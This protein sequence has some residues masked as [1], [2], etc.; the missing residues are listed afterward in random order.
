LFVTENIDDDDDDESQADAI[1]SAL[2]RDIEEEDAVI[3][4]I[5]QADNQANDKQMTMMCMSIMP[6]HFHK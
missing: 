2:L 5:R 3:C 6:L 1:D 4:F